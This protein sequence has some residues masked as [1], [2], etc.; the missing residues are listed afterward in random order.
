[1]NPRLLLTAMATAALWF[2]TAP[3]ASAQTNE[4][5]VHV[6]G[7]HL[8]D[9]RGSTI[10]LLGVNRSG[11]QYAC[12]E[13]WG[14]FDGPSDAASIQAMRSWDIDAVRVPLNEDCWLGINGADPAYSG[15]NY[16]EAIENYVTA[17][18]AQGL[19]AVLDLH[20]SAP[21]SHLAVAQEQMANADHSPAFWRSAATAF[22]SD[23]GVVFDL[24]NEP[25]GIS[26]NCWLH[27]CYTAAGWKAAGMQ[28]LLDAVRSTGANQ[29]VM[30]AG[31]NYA[32]DLEGWVAHEPADPDH[33]LIAAAHVYDY[34][35]CGTS[36][37]WHDVLAPLAEKVPVVTGELGET[38]CGTG[39]ID[40]Y[41]S[42]AD[43]HGVSY[44]GWSWDTASCSHG[45]ALITNYDGQPT[46]FGAGFEHHLQSLAHS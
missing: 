13:G 25:H 38:D 45:P 40:S 21:G 1:M 5:A 37:C 11:T 16:R 20:W 32:S 31:N 46:T 6:S 28:T 10:R 34:N 18:N 19:I 15:T 30:I 24:Y 27:G 44:L 39:F 41:M 35:Q 26:W 33:Q 17:L 22:K 14:I 8:E 9:A 43:G 23:P 2:V 36:T 4:V 12:S 7:N 29:P 42:W 3:T